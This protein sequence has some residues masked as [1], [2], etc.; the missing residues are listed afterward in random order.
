MM[1][2]LDPK[3][4]ADFML[5][6]GWKTLVP[7]PGTNQPWRA[8]HLPCGSE[9]SPRMHHIQAGRVGC[10]PCGHLKTINAQ[11]HDSEYAISIMRENNWDPVEP[12][13][14]NK[15]FWKSVCLTCGMESAPQF[16]NVIAGIS[17]CG[18]C[19]GNKVDKNEA[20]KIMINAGLEPQEE[21]PGA[22]KPWESKCMKCES[23]TYPRFADVKYGVRCS[24]C[25]DTGI[26]FSEPSYFYIMSNQEFQSIKV[27]ISNNES[28]SNRI[29][30][31]QKF[32]WELNKKY[33]FQTGKEAADIE[34]SVLYWLR[35][36]KKLNPHL[37][38]EMM[39]SGG[40]SETVDANEISVLEIEKFVKVLIKGL[41]K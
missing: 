19:S 15:H 30:R 12:Y 31:H 9:G 22:G 41:Q 6:H 38:K 17:H 37:S 20:F 27:G 18:Y 5:S 1:K 33:L 4:A 40:F 35:K 28:N 8:L 10:V 23:L 3:D 25:S 2:R 32:G 24:T 21:Y 39:P 29:K 7:Y 26:N 13:V 14:N 34:N 36:V 16:G 11:R